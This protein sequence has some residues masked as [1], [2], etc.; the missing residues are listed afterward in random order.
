MKKLLIL[1]LAFLGPLFGDDLFPYAYISMEY[2]EGLVYESCVG[3]T[4]SVTGSKLAGCA[5]TWGSVSKTVLRVT[6]TSGLDGCWLGKAYVAITTA[7]VA[8]DAAGN[9]VSDAVFGVAAGSQDWSG[10]EGHS[11]TTDSCNAPYT[12]TGPFEF[13]CMNPGVEDPVQD[14]WVPCDPTDPWGECYD[15]L[16]CYPGDPCYHDPDPPSCNETDP[17]SLCYVE[18]QCDP[19]DPACSCPSGMADCNPPYPPCDPCDPPPVECNPRNPNCSGGCDPNDP[20]CGI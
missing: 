10:A 20:S 9:Q 8:Q 15:P 12:T 13:F 14:P 2:P 19:D 16:P 11:Y 6:V 18:P 7:G 4:C 3:P 17:A 5:T 1:A